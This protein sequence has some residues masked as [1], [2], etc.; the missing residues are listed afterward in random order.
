MPWAWQKVW[1]PLNFLSP[2]NRYKAAKNLPI[3]NNLT[4]LLS[5]F[6]QFF[7]YSKQPV[8]L[9]VFGVDLLVLG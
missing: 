1:M 7:Y 5:I 6:A 4:V 2:F 9:L 3:I 8:Y